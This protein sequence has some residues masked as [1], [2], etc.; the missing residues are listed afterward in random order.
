LEFLVGRDSRD[1][2]DRYTG[3][4]RLSTQT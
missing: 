2:E 1:V 3:Q 4:Q